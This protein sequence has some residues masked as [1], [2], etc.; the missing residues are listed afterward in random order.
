M[1]DKEQSVNEQQANIDAKAEHIGKTFTD[2]IAVDERMAK[3]KHKIVVL[4]GKGGVGKSTVAANLALSLAKSG[5]K[6]GL[7]D[8]DIHGPSIPKLMGL[9]NAPLSGTDKTINPII[10]NENLSVMSIGFM[11]PN[12]D[13]P[14]IWRGPLKFSLIKQFL[15][16]VEWGELDYLVID[17]PPGTGDE[18]LTIVQLLSNI[19][20]AVVV[21]TPQDIAIEDVRKSISFCE[22]VQLPILGVI[23][24]MSGFIC[25]HCG[26]VTEVFKSGGGEKMSIDMKVPFLGAIPMDANVVDASDNGIS[27]IDH[28]PKSETAKAFQKV[29]EPLLDIQDKK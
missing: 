20:G 4:S 11:M 16:D 24:N 22:K 15:S 8:I 12:H 6:V 7:M 2:K 14:V 21:T 5:K 29:I 18:P 26:E 19:D 13:D 9:E 10:K 1:S 28:Y 23:E 17:S 27:F 3:V 25:P